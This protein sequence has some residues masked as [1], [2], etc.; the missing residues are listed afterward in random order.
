MVKIRIIAVGKDKDAWVTD[1]SAHFLKLLKRYASVEQVHLAGPRTSS[2]LSPEQS[3]AAEAGPILEQMDKGTQIALSD[4]GRPMDSEAFAE[5]IEKLTATS[6]PP[7]SIVIGG[8]YGLDQTVL[9]RADH[10]VS[11]SPLTFSHQ[12]VRLVLLEQLYRAFSI[13]AGTDYHK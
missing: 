2:S 12:I 9:D 4:R 13:L 10:V 5:F 3:K 6:P 1:G 8:P 11:L 7:L